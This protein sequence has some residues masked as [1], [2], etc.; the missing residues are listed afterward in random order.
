MSRLSRSTSLAVPPSF[1][2]SSS[3][4]RCL[5]FFTRSQTPLGRLFGIC[6]ASGCVSLKC[7]TC[8]LVLHKRQ[9]EGG[10]SGIFCFC[11][12]LYLSLALSLSLFASFLLSLSRRSVKRVTTAAVCDLGSSLWLQL[13][14]KRSSAPFPCTLSPLLFLLWHAWHAACAIWI[15]ILK[16]TTPR[17]DQ[18]LSW[19]WTRVI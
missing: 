18:T 5:P 7:S 2:P 4:V 19:D 13:Q 11:G 3:S 15:S 16:A 1:S 12:F 8:H 14:L 17:A 6:L 10:A 9:T